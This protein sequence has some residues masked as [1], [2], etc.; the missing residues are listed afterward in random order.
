MKIDNMTPESAKG[1]GRQAAFDGYDEDA[2]PFVDEYLHECWY[3]GWLTAM[4]EIS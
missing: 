2:N 3:D 4:A 1:L